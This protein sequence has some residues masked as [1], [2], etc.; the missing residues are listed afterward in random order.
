MGI[1]LA[2][3]LALGHAGARCVLTY[4]WGGADEDEVLRSFRAAGAPEP[5]ILRC[6]AGDPQAVGEAARQ[7][8]SR[9][10][11]LD[12]FVSNVAFARGIRRVE[13]Y[14]AAGIERAVAVSAWPLVSHVEAFQEA[15]LPAPAR[16][17]AISSPGSRKFFPCY[18][19]AAAAKAALESLARSMSRRLR[20]R[21]RVFVVRAGF[22]ETESVRLLLGDLFDEVSRR[23]WMQQFR[24]D[25]AGVGRVV[26]MLCGDL[27]NGLAGGVITVDHGLLFAARA[28]DN[29]R[30]GP[31]HRKNI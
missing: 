10:G 30:A 5:A 25:P 2:S 24:L 3:A 11:R 22:I 16:I 23:A 20:G 12:V 29:H 31:D 15:G 27:C 9:F 19:E 13:D 17:V 7:I 28:L 18:D 1:G 26:R 6:D 14:S 4:K 8:R 21:S